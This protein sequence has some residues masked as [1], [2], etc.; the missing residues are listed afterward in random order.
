[1]QTMI[2]RRA[3]V[4]TALAFPLVFAATPHAGLSEELA[5]D[6]RA[7]RVFDAGRAPAASEEATC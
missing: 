4:T 7:S 3:F 5:E 1:M 6:I 2:D